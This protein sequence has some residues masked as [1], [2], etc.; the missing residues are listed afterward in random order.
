MGIEFERD[1][2]KQDKWKARQVMDNQKIIARLDKIVELLTAIANGHI[3]QEG[4]N[5][6]KN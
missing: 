4:N 6:E 2:D 1:N 3:V 5:G